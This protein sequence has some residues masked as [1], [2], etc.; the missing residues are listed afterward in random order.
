[1]KIALVLVVL[2][3]LVPNEMF[4]TLGRLCLR[5]EKAILLAH[6]L[7]GLLALAALAYLK[8]KDS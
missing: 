5:H 4:L 6:I 8:H 2:I 1:M 7:G 3:L